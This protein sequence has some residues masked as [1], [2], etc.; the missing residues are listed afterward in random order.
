MA[1]NFFENC[2]TIQDVHETVVNNL[3]ELGKSE[4]MSQYY[5]AYEKNKEKQI[6]KYGKYKKPAELSADEFIEGIQRLLNLTKIRKYVNGK[7]EG[8]IELTLRYSVKPWGVNVSGDTMLV[9]EY[10]RGMKF[11]WNANTMEWWHNYKTMPE[12][13]E[14]PK[15]IKIAKPVETVKPKESKKAKVVKLADKKSENAKT[16]GKPKLEKPVAITD[17]KEKA[18]I[19]AENKAKVKARKE[20][21]ERNATTT[22]RA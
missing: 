16:S 3:K 12:A 11:H 6:G 21:R 2:K 10:L 5:E 4:F 13:V 20:S 1:K 8:N 22:R 14:L 15:S 18:R 9:R 7:R 19:F 17:P